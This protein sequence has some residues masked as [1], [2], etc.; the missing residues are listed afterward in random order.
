MYS[1]DAYARELSINMEALGE[2]PA[3]GPPRTASSGLSA[4]VNPGVLGVGVTHEALGGIKLP[5][6]LYFSRNISAMRKRRSAKLCAHL[7][8]YLAEVVCKFGANPI[9]DDVTVTSEVK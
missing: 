1:G 5:H 8:E 6:P 4:W 9:S 3:A 7:P 2:A